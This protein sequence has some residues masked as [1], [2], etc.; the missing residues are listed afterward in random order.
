MLFLAENKSGVAE[1]GV[2][3]KYSLCSF[4]SALIAS[5]VY[6]AVFIFPVLRLTGSKLSAVNASFFALQSTFIS[7]EIHVNKVWTLLL[8]GNKWTENSTFLP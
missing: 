4:S 8:D 6:C 2:V 1:N 7:K 5:Q 3:A